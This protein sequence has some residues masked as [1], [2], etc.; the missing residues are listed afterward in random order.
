MTDPLEPFDP[1]L[2]VGERHDEFVEELIEAC[3][4]PLDPDAPSRSCAESM[5]REALGT[6]PFDR[7]YKRAPFGFNYYEDGV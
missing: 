2:F 6:E 5:I 7:Q 4:E 1:P 3:L